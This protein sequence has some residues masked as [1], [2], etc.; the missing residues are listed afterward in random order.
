[1]LGT[2][3]TFLYNLAHKLITVGHDDYAPGISSPFSL[4]HSIQLLAAHSTS[5]PARLLCLNHTN[6]LLTTVP[7]HKLLKEELERL[8]SGYVT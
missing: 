4:F 2:V 5:R 7:N 6:R 1:M 8:S 3:P